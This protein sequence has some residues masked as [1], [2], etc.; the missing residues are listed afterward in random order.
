[1][2]GVSRDRNNN[3]GCVAEFSF[4]AEDCVD[5]VRA[6]SGKTT[7]GQNHSFIWNAHNSLGMTRRLSYRRGQFSQRFYSSK[8]EGPSDC[9]RIVL[10]AAR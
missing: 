6:H 7:K 5:D 10:A 2:H 1:M 3:G 9:Y 8:W 4:L